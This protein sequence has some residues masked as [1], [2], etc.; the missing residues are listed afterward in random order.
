[1]SLNMKFHR[2]DNLK[3][4]TRLFVA[5]G[6]CDSSRPAE[7]T[8]RD[9]TRRPETSRYNTEPLKQLYFCV[10]RAVEVWPSS[11]SHVDC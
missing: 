6:K 10:W 11:D 9:D 2:R 8:P 4:Y 1:M 7:Q 5:A 3:S